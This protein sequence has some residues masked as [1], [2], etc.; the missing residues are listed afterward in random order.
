MTNI[1]Q[2]QTF[3]EVASLKSFT[4][5]AKRLHVPRTTVTARI[6]AL[7][8]RLGVQLLQRTTRKVSLTT[9]GEHF[10]EQC[11]PALSALNQAEGEILESGELRGLIRFS[12]PLDYPG[13]R[14]CA[15][16]E[17]FRFLHPLV[18]FQVDTS[19]RN[20]DF[21]QE[22]YDLS[23][24]GKNPGEENLI[25]RKYFSDHSAFF[26]TAQHKEQFPKMLGL[27][28]LR[29]REIMDPGHF[30]GELGIEG[31][32]EPPVLTAGFGLTKTVLKATGGLAVLPVSLCRQEEKRGELVRLPSSFSLPDIPLFIVMPARQYR[33]KRVREF[34][35][36]LLA[37]KN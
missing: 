17:K 29:G 6:Q 9:E 23:I 33:P 7:E 36:F 27:E 37:E 35:D 1:V 14:L 5:A 30:L 13:D 31:V 4:A 10:L 8:L 25:A 20:V 2:L 28:D 18:R 24:R 34:I 19:D 32:V 26:T 21:V 12:V 22:N 11:K 15:L 16:L 3:V